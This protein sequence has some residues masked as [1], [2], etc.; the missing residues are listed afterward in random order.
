MS[1]SYCYSIG[2]H[3]HNCLTP[4]FEI[5]K[6]KLSTTLTRFFHNVAIFIFFSTHASCYVIFVSSPTCLFCWRIICRMLSCDALRDTMSFLATIRFSIAHMPL[7]RHATADPDAELAARV[8]AMAQATIS[9][10]EAWG[11]CRVHTNSS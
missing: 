9:K 6:H 2:Q 4:M 1:C 10:K 3:F 7:L 11:T 5:T 8:E